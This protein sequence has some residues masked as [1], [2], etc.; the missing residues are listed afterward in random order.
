MRLVLAVWVL[1]FLWQGHVAQDTDKFPLLE[2]SPSEVAQCSQLL[3]PLTL[4]SFLL[5]HFER[6]PLLLRRRADFLGG[7]LTSDEMDDLLVS[8]F[9]DTSDGLLSEGTVLAGQGER[10]RVARRVHRRGVWSSASPRDTSLTLGEV[11]ALFLRGF[12][13]IV[14]RAELFAG[15]VRRLTHALARCLGFRVSANVYFTPPNASAFEAHMDWMDG[16]VVQLQGEKWWKVYSPSLV[17]LPRPDTVRSPYA[18]TGILSN[19]SAEE[20]VLRSGDLLYIPRGLVHEASTAAGTK[21][22]L[23]ITFGIEVATHFTPQVLLHHALRQYFK[24][25]YPLG[26]LTFFGDKSRQ[27]I[28][29]PRES[30]E[31]FLHVCLHCA[32]KSAEI[33]RRAI[34]L[35]HLEG[36]QDTSIVRAFKVAKATIANFAFESAMQ[37]ALGEELLVINIMSGWSSVR[38]QPLQLKKKSTVAY[39][40]RFFEQS[41]QSTVYVELV[42]SVNFTAGLIKGFYYPRQV[43]NAFSADSWTAAAA[44]LSGL[45]EHYL[46]IDLKSWDS[47]IADAKH[48]MEE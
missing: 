10:W 44:T 18:E 43:Q 25:I 31:Q 9:G 34:R 27:R 26:D 29:V 5:E 6:A 23:H 42:N 30:T 3:H 7:L 8:A 4:S 2:P 20:V 19:L 36:L 46:Q 48:H 41:F 21:P 24:T 47:F 13:L 37:C 38:L 16:L 28:T 14:N 40:G 12:S 15:R 22:S 17:M 39:I 1:L 11:H 35:T 33:L 45:W 32:A